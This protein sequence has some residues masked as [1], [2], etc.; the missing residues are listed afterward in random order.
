MCVTVATKNHWKK[1]KAAKVEQ[2]THKKI[3]IKGH[4]N[5]KSLKVKFKLLAR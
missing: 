3:Y 1:Q 5:F 2:S 4:A